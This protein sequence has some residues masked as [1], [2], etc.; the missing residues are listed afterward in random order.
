MTKK[1]TNIREAIKKKKWKKAV[2]LT[3]WVDPPSPEAVRKMWKFFDKLSYL[4]LFCHFIKEKMGQNFHKIEAVRLEGGGCSC[5][6][7]H[8][9]RLKTF[10]F[11]ALLWEIWLKRGKVKS[12][13][14]KLQLSVSCPGAAA[15]PQ[16]RKIKLMLVQRARRQMNA[17]SQFSKTFHLRP[18]KL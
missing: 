7:S 18:C 12:M 17:R 16:W 14:V 9:A 6:P 5:P 4:G 10:Y 11:L 3:A 13:K 2:R 1:H 8:R 15:A